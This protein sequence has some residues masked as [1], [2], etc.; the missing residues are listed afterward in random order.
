MT[1]HQAKPKPVLPAFIRYYRPHRHLLFLDLACAL[2]ISLIDLAF[3][4]ASRFA[5][6]T[7]LPQGRYRTFFLLVF[8][9]IGLYLIRS[10]MH[11]V[12]NYWGHMLGAR[13]E[14]DMRRDLF[15][16]LQKLSHRFYDNT[17]TGQLMSRVINDLFEISELAHHGP[18]DLFLSAIML[19]GSFIALISIEWRLALVLFT[20]IPLFIVFVI[21]QRKR[22]SN[23]S[24][25]VKKKTAAI[26]SSLENSISGIRVA[27]A[28]VNEAYENE[29]FNEGN[30]LY[31]SAKS[32][33][34]QAMAVFHSGMTLMTGFLNV[35]VI[36][37]GGLL[38]QR[39]LM[40]FADLIAFSLYVQS[41][42]SPVQKLGNFVE[43]YTAGMAGFERFTEMMAVDPEIVDAADAVDLTEVT[44]T[45]RFE[46]V[47]FAYKEGHF[48][49][50]NLNL[51]IP[52][53]STLALVGPSGGGKTTLCHLIPRF[54]DVTGGSILLD[55]RDIKTIRLAS[56]R[57]KIGIV[58]QDVF[59]FA[60]SIL[61]NIRYG[62]IHATDEA[63][64]QAARLADIHDFIASLP[65]G[66][67]TEVGE[68]GIQL[69]G[70]QKQRISIAR[71]FLKNPP[72]LILD[73][74]TSALDNE[75]EHRIQASLDHLSR[76]RTTLVIAHR[77]TT[78]RKAQTIVFIDEE[79]IRE[80]GS[81]EALIEQNGAYA[82]LYRA[83]LSRDDR[84][85][86]DSL[87]RLEG[88]LPSDDRLHLSAAAF[89]KGL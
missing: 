47:T 89:R 33:F 9:F 7:L 78:V 59:L 19:T 24:K 2:V 1:N 68:R 21:L 15:A 22:M 74:A 40:D 23:A 42:L 39:Q 50:E 41:F 53:G 37:F 72:I 17:R 61:D 26:N 87:S 77:L 35:C 62:N 25:E 43:Q 27:K 57:E 30:S 51:E 73:E 71:I 58:Q 5:L 85:P 29:K 13:M 38:I 34:Y 11:Y 80:V 6:Q 20:A 82:R 3:P 46:K 45:I 88:P 52:A 86:V 48:V 44:G 32:G 65:D 28:F 36:G 67:H 66:Y 56:L 81:H 8:S 12:I 79:G 55:G 49:L 75:T 16:H 84:D 69:S 14:A 76:G 18:E 70:G 10:G 63:V 60:G 54:Y 64:E 31:R 4:M 83:S